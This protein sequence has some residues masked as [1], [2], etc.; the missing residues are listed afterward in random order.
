MQII[1]IKSLPNGHK[2]LTGFGIPGATHTL[3]QTPTLNPGNFTSVAPVTADAIGNWQF[4][5]AT[6]ATTRFYRLS[7]P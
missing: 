3:Q 5:D 1:S 4:E 2:L 7:F 6:T